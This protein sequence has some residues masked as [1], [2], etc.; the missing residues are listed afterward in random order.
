ME[1]EELNIFI[2]GQQTPESSSS[3]YLR[4]SSIHEAKIQPL[5]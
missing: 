3:I 5:L 2:V 1:G 4:V